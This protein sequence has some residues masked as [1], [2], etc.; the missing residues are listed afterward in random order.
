MNITRVFSFIIF[1]DTYSAA[2][3]CY[4]VAVNGLTV[5]TEEHRR[6]VQKG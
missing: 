6:R 1:T 4:M 5:K 2:A 3:A